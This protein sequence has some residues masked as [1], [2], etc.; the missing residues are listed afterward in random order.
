MLRI[1]FTDVLERRDALR[2][3]PTFA[4]AARDRRFVHRLAAISMYSGFSLAKEQPT[5]STLRPASYLDKAYW[6]SMT[7]SVLRKP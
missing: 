1:V 2:R 3:P 4:R 7:L 5:S 6:I